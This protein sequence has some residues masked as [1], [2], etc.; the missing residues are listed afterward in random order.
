MFRNIKIRGMLSVIIV[1]FAFLALNMKKDNP[2]SIL[3]L[4]S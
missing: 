1:F 2:F 3:L 4:V